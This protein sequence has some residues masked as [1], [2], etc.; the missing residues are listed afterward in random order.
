MPMTR[1]APSRYALAIANCPTG[2]QPQTAIVSPGLMSHI[3]APM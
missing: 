1:S 2:P 3:S